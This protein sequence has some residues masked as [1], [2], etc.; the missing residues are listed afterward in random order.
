VLNITF[1]TFIIIKYKEQANA[2]HVT[3]Q[4]L[5]IKVLFLF[6]MF[7]QEGR[8]IRTNNFYFINRD[9]NRLNYLSEPFY[10]LI[11]ICS[12]LFKIQ[13]LAFELFNFLYRSDLNT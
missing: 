11:Y 5:H 8:I 2:L 4:L 9:S 6:Y 7:I 3:S 10:V 1:T 12:I 13:R